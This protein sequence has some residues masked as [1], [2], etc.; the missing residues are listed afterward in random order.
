MTPNSAVER[1][2]RKRR[3]EHLTLGFIKLPAPAAIE[4][5]A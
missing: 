2:R 5:N 4:T 1:T 3:A